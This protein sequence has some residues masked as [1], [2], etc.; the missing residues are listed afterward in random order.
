MVSRREE[1]WSCSLLH[2]AS[3]RGEPLP[4]GPKPY[5]LHVLLH[6][7]LHSAHVVADYHYSIITGFMAT[8][9]LIQCKLA[10]W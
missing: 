4:P 3:G 5:N 10:Y 7:L 1:C 9:S 2:A 8:Y 6:T